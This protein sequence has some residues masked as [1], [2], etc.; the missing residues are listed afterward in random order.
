MKNSADSEAFKPAEHLLQIGPQPWRNIAKSDVNAR[1]IERLQPIVRDAVTSGRSMAV[2][3]EVFD[4][5]E[6]GWHL[7]VQEFQHDDEMRRLMG[8]LVQEPAHINNHVENWKVAPVRFDARTRGIEGPMFEAV[9][10]PEHERA[11]E[12]VPAILWAWL[13]GLSGLMVPGD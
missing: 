3:S 13:F 12:L 11:S 2:P 5:L 7:Q 6:T 4:G 10:S 1:L 8:G 9:I